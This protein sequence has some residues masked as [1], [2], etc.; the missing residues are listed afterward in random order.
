MSSIDPAI[1][2][3]LAA[4]VAALRSRIAFA[5]AGKQLTAQ[6]LQGAAVNQLIE[7]AARMSHASGKGLE[8]DA[9][10]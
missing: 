5:V 3:V 7:A 8:F 9:V 10:A 1:S 6:A 2:S 4:K